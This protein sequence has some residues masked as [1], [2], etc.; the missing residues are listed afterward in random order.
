MRSIEDGE[1]REV[2]KVLYTV[3]NGQASSTMNENEYAHAQPTKKPK[4]DLEIP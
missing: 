2:E 4:A 3:T 1:D